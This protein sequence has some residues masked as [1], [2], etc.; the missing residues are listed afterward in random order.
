MAKVAQQQKKMG[1]D[2]HVLGTTIRP[3]QIVLVS[4]L[5]PIAGWALV[6]L[7]WGRILNFPLWLMFAGFPVI[8][9]YYWQLPVAALGILC[10][11]GFLNRGLL[12]RAALLLLF[13]SSLAYTVLVCWFMLSGQLLSS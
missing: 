8:L 13:I 7:I 10:V 9:Y 6:C 5:I 11:V 1:N 12:I 4:L 2:F 3:W